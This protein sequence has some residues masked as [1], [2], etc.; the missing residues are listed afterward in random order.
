[1]SGVARGKAGEGPSE[2]SARDRAPVV[3]R[4]KPSDALGWMSND[5]VKLYTRQRGHCDKIDGLEQSTQRTNR[6][7]RAT[8][9]SLASQTQSEGFQTHWAAAWITS[10]ADCGVAVETTG[11]IVARR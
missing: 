1:M 6:S 4:E 8:L 3:R 5:V 2:R 7:Y 11:R 9:P 10:M